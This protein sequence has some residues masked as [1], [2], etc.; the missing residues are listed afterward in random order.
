MDRE[1][2]CADICRPQPLALTTRHC[3]RLLRLVLAAFV[4]FTGLWHPT[5]AHAQ[6]HV[7]VF[8][9]LTS[10]DGLSHNEVF[11]ILQDDYGFMW[12]GTQDGLNRYDGYTITTYR[13][14]RA[15]PQSLTANT[16]F[17]LF[18][19]RAGTLWVG[20]SMGLDS[21]VRPGEQFVHYATIG[22]EVRAI[23]EDAA[24]ILWIGTSSAGLWSY[25]RTTG[26]FF[27]Y[28]PDPAD[29]QSLGDDSI[30]AIFEDSSGTLWI[31]TAGGGLDALGGGAARASGGGSFI[32]YRH[33]PQDP[34]S[35]S[36]DYVTAIY[37]DH[38]GVLWVGTV[39][40]YEPQNGGLNAFDRTTGQFTRYQHD[41]DDRHS[42]SNN[43]VRTIYEDRSGNLWV[44]T[45]DGLNALDRTTGTFVHCYHDPLDSR[46]LSNN[47]IVTIYEDRSGLLWI[48]TN[49]GGLN[50]YAP[51]MDKFV[52]YQHDPLD[53]DT[54]SDAPVAAVL[55]DR[56]GDLW[57]GTHGA[58]LDRL[59]H[60]TGQFLH[61]THDPD[62]PTSLSNDFVRA[63]CED[64][65][66]ILWVGTIVGLDRFDPATGQF[67]HYVHDPDD[68][69]SLNPG[70]V[71]AIV[72]D[73]T[74]ALWIGLEEPGGLDKLDRT[75]GSFTHFE[76]DPE[77]PEGFINTY[78]VRAIYEDKV[79]DLWLGTYNGLVHFDRASE[80]F[81]QY[82]PDPDD[83]YSLSHDFVWS[84]CEEPAGILW[85]GTSGGLN[86]RDPS[87]GQF[88]VYTV[89]DGLA[90][91]DVVGILADAAGELWIGTDGGG[92][93]RFDPWTG[94]FRNYGVRDGL[95]SKAISL[96][97]CYQSKKGQMFFG[98]A[99]GVNAFYPAAV[100]DNDYIPPVVLTAFKVFDQAVALASALPETKEVTL[101]YQDN[102]ISFEFAALDYT[103]PARNQYAYQLE[104]F[105]RSWAYCGSRRFVSYTNL[106]PGTYTFRVKGSNNDGVWNEAGQ[107]LRIT[108]TPPF[109]ATWWFRVTVGAV[110]LGILYVVVRLRLRTIAVLRQ[111]EERFR[112]LFENAP[113]CVFELDTTTDPPRIIRAN[114]KGRHLFAWPEEELAGTLDRVFPPADW[115]AV[116]RLLRA[117]QAGETAT[118]PSSG[119]SRDG[120]VFPVRVSATGE[121]GP[122]RK[123]VILTLEDTTAE[124][125]RRSE[126][127]AIAEERRRIAREIHDGVAQDLAGLRFRVRLWHNLVDDNPAQMH[128]ELDGL[129]EVLGK[130]IREVRRSI[131]ALRPVALDE[132][133]FYP[134]LHQF[135]DEFAEQNQLHINL[136]ITG[137]PEQ[138]PNFLEPV[139][140]RMIQEALNNVGKH[141]QAQMV[142]LTLDLTSP[143]VIAL[144]IQDD[145]VG[146]DPAMLEQMARSG[147]LGLKQMRERVEK[148]NGTLDLHSQR[149]TGTAIHAVLPL[150]GG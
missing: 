4:V 18:Q 68:L 71:K 7:P 35:L 50:K 82:R 83:P 41:S 55:E 78:G 8:T 86:R 26:Q 33:D 101:S 45:D 146:F 32:H 105:D 102:F 60:R 20:T 132:L 63:L 49:G 77:R 58:G 116:Q 16:V 84:I 31:A 129:R 111:S 59:D 40:E 57:V 88:T 12:F 1:K 43:Q 47:N 100:K 87:T 38:L 22:E 93:S 90:G 89:E 140:F 134:A 51:S 133:G 92:L 70:G 2:D 46:S 3:G 148:L 74:G 9:H 138:L 119:L 150:R 54:L 137:P 118:L 125:A 145:G 91:D 99:N 28:M 144:H 56:R 110:V 115:P 139:L 103:D 15:D 27:Q 95:T 143:D 48:G 62:D 135:V 29:P 52:R 141:A 17:A 6:V 37:E 113:L 123:R 94:V 85:A 5:P 76:Y 107:A 81:T 131:F 67:Q 80:T 117:L 69:S 97:A 11:S 121:P 23:Y 72:E 149:G 114:R 34:H 130:N 42:L 124:K 36:Y 109:W 126:E 147:H 25:D 127:E 64:T 14:H 112:A 104:G 120:T 39:S 24:G 10:A 73:H 122:D 53:P 75:T 61:Y 142:W 19:D 13:H 128:T 65:D 98:T 136:R 108:I 30:T 79:G 21:L 96:A 66:G 106:P 44:G